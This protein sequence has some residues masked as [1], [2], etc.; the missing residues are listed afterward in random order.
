MGVNVQPPLGNHTSIR[1]LLH[2]SRSAFTPTPSVLV[3]FQREVNHLAMCTGTLPK[4]GQSPG[5]EE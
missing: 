3:P 4:G 1:P 5:N 2:G